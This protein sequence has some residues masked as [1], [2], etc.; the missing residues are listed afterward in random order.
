M[1][2]AR[3]FSAT[4]ADADPELAAAVNA[5]LGRQQSQI[6]LIASENIV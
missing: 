1:D 2:Q 3:F 5:E 6:E 4:L